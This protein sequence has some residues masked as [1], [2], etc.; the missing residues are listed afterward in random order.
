MIEKREIFKLQFLQTLFPRRL[1]LATLRTLTTP[2]KVVMRKIRKIIRNKHYNS[3][4][5]GT[6]RQGGV[7]RSPPS[8]QG[9]GGSR[10]DFF[11]K[12]GVC[13]LQQSKV[14]RRDLDK[15]D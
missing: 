7:C 5:Q 3:E 13:L 11:K 8:S 12:G 1:S 15:Q 6:L 2:F 14:L 10:R 9:A 4:M